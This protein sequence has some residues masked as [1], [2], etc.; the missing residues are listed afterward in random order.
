MD[1]DFFQQDFLGNSWERWA[2]AISLFFGV[3]LMGLAVRGLVVARL[4]KLAAK[5]ESLIDDLAVLLLRNTHFLFFFLIALHVGAG[6]LVLVPKVAK[7]IHVTFFLVVFTQVGLWLSQSLS[8]LG[9][10]YAD[11]T[12]SVDAG[13][14]TT[15][16]AM[17]F[18]G[19]IFIWV[20]M[21]LLLLDNWGIKVAPFLA[22]LGIGGIAIAFAV[23]GILSDLFASL[24]I[25]LD[26]PFVIGDAIGVD[27][28]S[29]TVEYIGL[30]T[31]RIRRTS[32][33]Q[34]VFS[35]SELLKSRIRNFK[36]MDERRVLLRIG[37]LYETDQAKI[38][39]IPAWLKSVVE[40]EPK[41][42]F[43]RAH[44]A[45]FGASALEYEMEYFVSSPDYG[46]YMDIQQKVSFE[47]LRKFQA[48]K[49]EFAYPTQKIFVEQTKA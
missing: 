9:N 18:F 37:V 30:K 39:S 38:E 41:T 14:A 12:L 34:L 22:G 44:F 26:K 42:R 17:I 36:R 35:N 46:I 2:L 6:S 7:I 4:G 31:T 29:G 5:T 40:K 1:M 3:L 11:R 13:R 19:R 15:V 10:D 28:D 8:F 23:Q 27:N 33:E 43:G 45:S 47:I 25:V 49:V 20:T 32:G 48:E 24:S 21:L 16:R